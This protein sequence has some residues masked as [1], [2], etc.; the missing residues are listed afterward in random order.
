[1]TKSEPTATTQAQDVRQ[2]ST[3]HEFQAWTLTR[4]EVDRAKLPGVAV[5]KFLDDV[6]DVSIGASS[7]LRLIEWDE[8][9]EEDH[10]TEPDAQ[11]QPVLGAYH[12]NVLLR[13]VAA[14]MSML[15]QKA[16]RMSSW[17]YEEHTPEGKAEVLADA[18]R[19]VPPHDHL[20]KDQRA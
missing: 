10:K 8:L 5:R 12:R 3:T 20:A 18:M 19:R 7:I 15:V 17:A 11:P 14:N 6:Y 16:E 2:R 9:R 4:E 1:M 13:L